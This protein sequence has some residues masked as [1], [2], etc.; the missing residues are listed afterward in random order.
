MSKC[1]K[2]W[3]SLVRWRFFN[4]NSKKTTIDLEQE[5]LFDF[6]LS[7]TWTDGAV[8]KIVTKTIFV[9]W[10]ILMNKSFLGFDW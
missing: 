7:W 4:S 5:I 6:S 8:Q 2:T 10:H 9:D 1:T 3:I